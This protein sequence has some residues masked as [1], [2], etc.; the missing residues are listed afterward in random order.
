MTQSKTL[1]LI[2]TCASTAI[3]FLVS[4]C[5]TA[6]VFPLYN[7]T[8]DAGVNFQITAIF[9]VVSILRGYVVRRA[10]SRVRGAA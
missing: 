6:V 9:T 7:L 10:F 8:I 3:G 2:E 5:V 4:M 1:S